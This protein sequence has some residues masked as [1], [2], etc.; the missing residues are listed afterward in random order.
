MGK[1]SI[2]PKMLV[3]F[4][5]IYSDNRETRTRSLGLPRGFQV[6]GTQSCPEDIS[7]SCHTVCPLCTAA[8][9]EMV[10]CII[11]SCYMFFTA[12]HPNTR[13]TKIRAVMYYY[14]ELHVLVIRVVP[15]ECLSSGVSL[16]TLGAHAQRGL[17]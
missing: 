9:W 7:S 2:T 14:I 15:L 3:F 4:S 17:L 8:G 11:W 12:S 5:M 10:V 6:K 13:G 16:L 1:N